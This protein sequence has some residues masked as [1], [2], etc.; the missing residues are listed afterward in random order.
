MEKSKANITTQ[1]SN[2][3]PTILVLPILENNFLPI[4]SGIDDGKRWK[5]LSFGLINSVMKFA[6][7]REDVN[8]ILRPRSYEIE[9]IKTLLKIFLYLCQ[10]I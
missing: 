2:L 4:Y 5:N 6:L 8:I 1:I 3:K 10:K 9:D 7:Q